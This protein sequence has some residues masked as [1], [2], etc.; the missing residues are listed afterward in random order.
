MSTVLK[1][2][3]RARLYQVLAGIFY[4]IYSAAWVSFAIALQR[5]IDAAGAGDLPGL[6]RALA[7][8]AAVLIP[9]QLATVLI[10]A[11]SRLN[12]GREMLLGVK[13]YRMAFIFAR[14]LKSPAQDDNKDLSFFTADADILDQSYYSQKGRLPLH[15]SS[16][17]FALGAMFWINWIVTVA[18]IVIS[19]IP[20]LVSNLFGKGLASRKKAYSDAAAEYVDVSRECIQGRR[21]I[22][23]YD[24]QDVFLKR[25][26]A[27]NRK[28]ETARLKSNFFEVMA[29]NVSGTMG[30][31][32][33]IAIFGI[34]SYFVITGDMTFGFMVAIVQLM[35]NVLS[36]I[37][38]IVET[39]NGM[40]S[41]KAILEKAG[42][43]APPEPAK[44]PVSDFNRAIEIKDLG[45]RYDEDEYVL[46]GLNLTFKRG[47]KYAVL[48]PS[49]YGKTSI[50]RALAM[51]FSEFDGAITIDGNDIRGL[52][53]SDYNK[54]LRYVR[55]DPYLFSDTAL[56]NL[57][58]FDEVPS[59]EELDRALAI[60]RVNEFLTDGEA[61][62]R[63]VSNNS[64]LS[65]GQKQRIVLARAL[66][67]KPKILVLDEITSGVDLATACDILTDLFKDKDLT[68]IAITHESDER[69]QSL[70]DEIVHLK[71]GEEYA[72]S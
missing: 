55:Q 23:A 24:K 11:R 71:G 34:S 47:N 37:H 30:G 57:A 2:S 56:N 69:F 14:R 17:V 21:E 67:H 29:G 50:A 58:F 12:F 68:C 16:F 49:G 42:E 45:L 36:P 15:I 13:G 60:T 44:S 28:V 39:L 43:T 5:G 64:G 3:P 7:F 6:I 32:T 63:R 62:N 9:L 51:E 19:M 61:L 70:F 18:A 48:A 59:K 38:S 65:G 41:S 53:T 1:T 33:T 40:R 10:A 31:F 4:V 54:I 22:V 66:L 46:K 27:E 35:N 20:L 72:A 25:H 8:T 26:E 52:N